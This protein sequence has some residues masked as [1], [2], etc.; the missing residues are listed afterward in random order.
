M[1]TPNENDNKDGL[2]TAKQKLSGIRGRPFDVDKILAA[3]RAKEERQRNAAKA[4]QVKLD[5]A[6]QQARERRHISREHSLE[7]E[8][9]HIQEAKLREAA[10]SRG[11]SGK[12]K[13]TR[14]K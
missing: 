1:S 7:S 10:K 3:N 14:S 12:S 6:I 13:D 11:S 9:E 4:A 2:E 8:N 5:K